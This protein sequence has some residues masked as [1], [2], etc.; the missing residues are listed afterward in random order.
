[1]ADP[2]LHILN[3]SCNALNK[4]SKIHGLEKNDL[5]QIEVVINT[6]SL[7]AFQLHLFK[8]E[9]ATDPDALLLID[10]TDSDIRILSHLI[11]KLGTLNDPSI[12]IESYLRYVDSQD[13][14]LLP[15]VLELVESTFSNHAI[16][17]ILPL[18][19]PDMDPAEIAP[20]L[21]GEKVLSKDE[22]LRFWVENPHR[23]KTN[24]S[25]QF[26]LRTENTHVLKKI[27][28]NLLPEG[29]LEFRYFSNTEREYLRRNF[30][31]N[32]FTNK[33]FHEMYSVLEKTLLLKSVDLFKTIPGDILSKIAQLAMEVQTGIDDMIFNE[34]D[35]G[36]SL[37]IIIS[38]KVSVT[39][40]GKSIAMLEQGHCIGEMS[41]LDQEPRSAGALAIED[42]ILLKIDQEGFY[43]LMS[44]NP[45]I[46]KQIVMML[47][48]RVREMNK[49]FTGSLS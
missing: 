40:G 17:L 36:D 42:S 24:I 33:E 27:K 1:M 43:E 6:L 39:R 30:I 25:T 32:N 7:R 4:I 45:D 46:M 22:M 49:K 21:L 35:H 47:T 8:N 38:G 29:L 14:D 3:A 41:L 2:D 5:K 44:S 19:D 20:D 34:G 13:P 26:L 28:W 11:L 31:N 9:L 10:H 37:Y 48:R 15:M 23:W 18:I 12:P 16:K